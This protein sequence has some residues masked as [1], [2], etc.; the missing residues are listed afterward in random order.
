MTAPSRLQLIDNLRSVFQSFGVV[1]DG[2]SDGQWRAQ[3]L[4]PAWTMHDVVVHITAIELALLG[5]RP[6][7]ENPFV[8]MA[9]I[10]PELQKL[11]PSELTR[12][13]H[14]VTTARI[15]EMT[16]MTD[17]EFAQPSLTPV[18][19]GTYGRFMAI[20][21]FDVWVHERDV[22]V[23]L[24]LDGDDSGS[25]AELALDEV[26]ASLGYIVGKK[27]GLAH[28]QGIAIELTGPVSRRLLAKVDGRAAR[29]DEL[30]SPD[31]TLTMDSLTFMLLACG[32]ID[33][34]VPLADGRVAVS[35]DIA[36][37]THAARNLSFT[38]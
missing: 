37:G 5:W 17:E 8:R 35:G 10:Q 28:G 14:E 15:G 19:P 21:C 6:G 38:M 1:V 34:E 11:S 27:I 20:R 25:A 7:D 31:I 13:Y 29:V 26:H 2:L 12:R 18:G 16:S 24:Y 4:C 9:T 22:R 3:S 30:P 23:P 36:L 32:R 33:P